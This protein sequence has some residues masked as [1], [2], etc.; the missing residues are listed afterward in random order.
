VGTEV[1]IVGGNFQRVS[2]VFLNDV[3]VEITALADN[4]IT[5]NVPHGATT[6]KIKVSTPK[7]STT[8]ADDFTVFLQPTITDFSPKEGLTGTEVVIMGSNFGDG[9]VA[10]FGEHPAILVDRQPTS[11]T[12]KVPAGS[13]PDKIHVT[14]S[15]GSA[16]SAEVFIANPPVITSITARYSSEPLTVGASGLEVTITCEN[17]PPVDKSTVTFGGVE[18]LNYGEV[19]PWS[20]YY[21]R[22]CEIPPGV[23]SGRFTLTINGYSATYDQ[24]VVV[25]GGGAW[26]LSSSISEMIN[27][28][29]AFQI[30][31]DFYF[32][33]GWNASTSTRNRSFHKFDCV[34]E[35]WSRLEDYPIEEATSIFSFAV[36]G[37]GYVSGGF[38]SNS[39]SYN[40]YQFDPQTGHWSMKGEFPADL[41]HLVQREGFSVNGKGYVINTQ[42][43]N[44]YEYDPVQD[45]WS[46]KTTVP[47]QM[48]IKS[49]EDFVI[50]DK[51]YIAFIR[52]ASLELEFWEYDAAGNAWTPKAAYPGVLHE[53]AFA[54]A[55]EGI[56]YLG[57][58]DHLW[59]YDPVADTWLARLQPF[60]SAASAGL[61]SFSFGKKGF[62]GLAGITTPARPHYPSYNELFVFEVP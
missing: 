34:S 22:W 26:R 59:K 36:N 46:L 58:S 6:G 12:V 13:Y 25:P 39:H 14:N 4:Q 41:P 3:E 18:V 16:M 1:K 44:V 48:P 50:N 56:G 24:E 9:T 23:A 43:G 27:N 61:P 38:Y 35:T 8:T 60:P 33:A 37:V 52:E 2:S 62:V 57:A 55:I 42:N 5:F 20:N 11:M 28:G 54:F 19:R 49:I 45:V 40:L 53:G 7:T 32:G 10:T 15:A 31:K 47:G 17:C 29:A 51:E 30:G 21:T